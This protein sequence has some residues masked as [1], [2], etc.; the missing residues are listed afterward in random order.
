VAVAEHAGAGG[1]AVAAPMVQKVM[2][3]YFDKQSGH[4]PTEVAGMGVSS[5]DVVRGDR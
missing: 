1:G 2:A 3:E 4:V 5:L